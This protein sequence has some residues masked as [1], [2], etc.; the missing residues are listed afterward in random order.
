[1]FDT[2]AGIL[3]IN[4]L[5]HFELSICLRNYSKCTST[6]KMNLCTYV[7]SPYK[8]ITK[9]YLTVT[10]ESGL[11]SKDFTFLRALNSA[12]LSSL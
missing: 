8:R 12:N 6:Y 11:D 9:N 2:F 3:V 5:T 1:M 7:R 4:Y 10:A